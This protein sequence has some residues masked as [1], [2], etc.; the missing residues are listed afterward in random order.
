[1]NRY[2]VFYSFGGGAR[3][4]DDDGVEMSEA[5]IYSKMLGALKED[6]DFFGLVD[7]HGTILQVMYQ[8]EDDSY[9]IEIPRPEIRGA[10]GCALSFDEITD[11]FKTLPAQ[12]SD[13]MHPKLVFGSWTRA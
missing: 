7:E 3:G 13:T 4:R 6:G 12:F 2:K 5:D 1:M 8:S 11:V 10:F 9:W